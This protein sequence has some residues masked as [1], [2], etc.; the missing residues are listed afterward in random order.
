MEGARLPPQCSVSEIGFNVDSAP[1]FYLNADSD[2]DPAFN[3]NAD[4]DLDP[5]FNLNADPAP[6]SKTNADPCRS[7]FGPWPDFEV[8]KSEFSHEKYRFST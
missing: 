3:L 5:A 8:I 6:G 7:G 2:P 4:S 1:A